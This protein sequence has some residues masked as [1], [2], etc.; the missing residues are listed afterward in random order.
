MYLI[1]IRS[2]KVKHIWNGKDTVCRLFSTGGMNPK[3]YREIIDSTIPT[4]TMCERKDQAAKG[5]KWKS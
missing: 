4:C 2:L 5:L 3:N 1:S